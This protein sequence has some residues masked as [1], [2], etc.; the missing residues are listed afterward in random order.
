MLILRSGRLRGGDDLTVGIEPIGRGGDD[1]TVG[2]GLIGLD[3]DRLTIGIESG[4]RDG[5]EGLR[6]AVF[7]VMG[8][9]EAYRLSGLISDGSGLE[10]RESGCRFAGGFKIRLGSDADLTPDVGRWTLPG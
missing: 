1:L 10:G 8:R 5:N 2:I 7:L 3:G 4:D 9:G 6:T